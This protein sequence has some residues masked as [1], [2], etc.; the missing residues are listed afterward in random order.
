MRRILIVEDDSP[1]RLILE[2]VL[3]KRDYE[4]VTAAEGETALGEIRKQPFDVLLTD[5]MMQPMD[6]MALLEAARGAGH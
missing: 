5:L 3:R 2:Q 1:L 6:G 4:V